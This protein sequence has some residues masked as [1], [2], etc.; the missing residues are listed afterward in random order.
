MLKKQKQRKEKL[1]MKMY[2]EKRKEY[3]VTQ[4]AKPGRS[5]VANQQEASKNVKKRKQEEILSRLQT[6]YSVPR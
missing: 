1:G 3:Q 4:L 5:S 6:R 2:R